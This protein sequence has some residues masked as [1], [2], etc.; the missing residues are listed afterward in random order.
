MGHERISVSVRGIVQ[1]VGFRPFL[2]RLAAKHRLTGWARNTPEGVRMELEGA[3]EALDAFLD[4]LSGNELPPLSR[5]DSV[6]T[7]PLPG[8]AGH[9]GFAILPSAEGTPAT[10]VAPDIATCPNCLRELRD[11]ADR[12]HGYPFINCTDCGPRFTII[13]KVPYDRANTTMSRFKM[14]PDCAA[15]YSDIE[16]RRYHAQ[17]DCCPVCGPKLDY[18]DG[19]GQAVPGEPLALARTLLE[20]GGIVA[21]KGLGGFH[22]ACVPEEDAVLR[23][24]QRKNRPARPLAV[25]CRDIAAAE[26]L[27][28]VSSAERALLESPSAPIVLCRKRVP[29]SLKAVSETD[30]LGLL[31]PYTPVHHLLFEGAAF[32]SLIFTSANQSSMPAIIENQMALTRL[33]GVADG[34]LLND[35]DIHTRCDDSLMFVSPDG[36]PAFIRRSR[37]F[38][39]APIPLSFSADGILALGAH[40]K[41]SFC[42]GRGQQAFPSQHIGDLQN[43]ETYQHYTRQLAH[44]RALFGF[45]PAGLVCDLHPD[46]LS[47]H[48][49]QQQGLPLL[50]VQ[51][52][53]A[54]MAACMADNGLEGDCIGLIW[55]GTGLGTDGSVWGSECL[56]G[57]Y[58]RF[59]RV[60]SIRPIP[61]PGGE[62]AILEIGRI[63]YALARDAGQPCGLLPDRQ[64]LLNKMIE[65][66]L[67]CP[68]S[69]GMGRLFDGVY[70]LLTGTEAAAYDG[71]APALLECLADGSQQLPWAVQI[72]NGV[73]DTRPMI[74]G[75]LRSG[76][77]AGALAEK[78]HQ[79]LIAL[80]VAMCEKARAAAGCDRVVLSGGCWLNRKLL[81]GVLEALPKAGFTVYH[82]RQVS[83]TDEGISFGQLAIAAHSNFER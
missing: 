10:L 76:L 22:L 38:A 40:Q 45:Q 78:F 29:G 81:A 64:P 19:N 31:L 37:G 73:W 47:T 21:V 25:L 36:I 67:N 69:S 51:H 56:V 32:D 74:A 71:Q 82:H 30:T 62:A 18:R 65:K 11:P 24:R 80:A 15:E 1:G 28:E 4:D 79:T 75:M 5:L 42:Y 34:F 41:A 39:P 6:E 59:E 55:D 8:L 70:A 66:Q 68:A 20:Q 60:C 54:H 83:T 53:H 50:Q 17:P 58:T 14:C 77:S 52:H 72:E 46:Y 3:R 23:L 43:V 63:G 33:A 26:K 7:T 35:R 48:Y 9:G 57:D 61:L 49:A 44:T 16:T 2:H 12:R 27:C 13:Q